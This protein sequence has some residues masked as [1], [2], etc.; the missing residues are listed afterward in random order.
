MQY[1]HR[2]LS[3]YVTKNLYIHQ[4]FRK[5]ARHLNKLKGFFLCATSSPFSFCCSKR[6]K[7]PI[8]PGFV[9][10]KSSLPKHQILAL[11]RRWRFGW[12]ASSRG[13]SNSLERRPGAIPQSS[14][15]WWPI[16]RMFQDLHCLS[17][18]GLGC[19][20]GHGLG[21]AS[22]G[23]NVSYILPQHPAWSTNT[24]ACYLNPLTLK[25]QR[26]GRGTK[27]HQRQLQPPHKVHL[28]R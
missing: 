5:K 7:M 19:V 4:L 16:V 22:K 18:P 24:R 28:H 17:S 11:H 2:L 9:V 23:H 3:R 27:S 14:K 21:V 20:H 10:V 26:W 12:P 13:F 6:V 25:I 1:I 8:S 15:W